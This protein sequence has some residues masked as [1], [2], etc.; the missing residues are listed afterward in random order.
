M[1]YIF[2]HSFNH[3]VYLNF[4]QY[5]LINSSETNNAQI[6]WL[7][8]LKESRNRTTLKA[9]NNILKKWINKI[10]GFRKKWYTIFPIAYHE[11][12]RFNILNNILKAQL[13]LSVIATSLFCHFNQ[14]FKKSL[15]IPSFIFMNHSVII[16]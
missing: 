6:N 9:R 12:W 10:L 7:S 5:L 3:S 4:F 14:I 2:I 11:S 8:F 16:W 15:F 13:L 1:I